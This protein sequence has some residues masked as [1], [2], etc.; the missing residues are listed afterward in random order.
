MGAATEPP[1]GPRA[2][3]GY[4]SK[5]PPQIG[6]MHGPSKGPWQTAQRGEVLAVAHALNNAPCRIHIYTDS[7]YVANTLE[8]LSEAHRHKVGITTSGTSFG[9]PEPSWRR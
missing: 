3:W 6:T 1:D 9:V 4:A 8:K 5:H 7:R 2:R